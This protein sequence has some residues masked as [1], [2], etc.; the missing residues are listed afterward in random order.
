MID[1]TDPDISD[2]TRHGG[3]LLMYHG[4]ADP[5]IAPTNAINYCESV[6]QAIGAE[7]RDSVRLFMVPGMGHCGGGPGFHNIDY[8]GALESGSKRGHV[9]SRFLG[10]T[11]VPEGHV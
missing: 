2:F 5:N 8:L 4:W 11:R 10:E 6:R 7:A 9:L 1:A 3:K